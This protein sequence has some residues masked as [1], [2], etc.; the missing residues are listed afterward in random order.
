ME[1]GEIM[2]IIMCIFSVIACIYGALGTFSA[3]G[4]AIFSSKFSSGGSTVRGFA[5]VH[6]IVALAAF[7]VSYALYVNRNF[8][9]G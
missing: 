4:M 6:F 9:L 2:V 3:I 5:L 1:T 8:F 7:G